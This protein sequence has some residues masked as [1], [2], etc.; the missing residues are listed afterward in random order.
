MS[1]DGDG[2][3]QGTVLAVSVGGVRRV[4]TGSRVVET[5]IWKT[6]VDGRVAVRGVNLDGDDQADRTVHGGPDKAVYAYAIEDTR[7]WEAQLGRELGPAAFGE[8]LTTEGLDLTTARLGDRWRV[9]STLLEVCQTR[10]PC[11]KLGLRMGDPTFLKTFAVARRPGAYLRILEEGDVGAGDAVDV[12]F[13][14]DH[15]VTTGLLSE[16]LLHD[17]DL[18]PRLLEAPALPLVFREWIAGLEG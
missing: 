10:V 18:L 8:N 13:R 17:H 15:E 16:A 5:G 6:P 1:Q 9:G 7:W 4:P 2:Q 11:F 12:V 14:P 3:A